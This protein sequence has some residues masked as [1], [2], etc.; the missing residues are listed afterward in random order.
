MFAPKNETVGSNVKW[1]GVNKYTRYVEGITDYQIKYEG[2]IRRVMFDT[3]HGM[4]YVVIDKKRVYLDEV[5]RVRTRTVGLGKLDPGYE[6]ADRTAA[7]EHRARF[8]EDVAS[9]AAVTNAT[10]PIPETVRVRVIPNT[11]S[12]K[13]AVMR[14]QVRGPHGE[15]VTRNRVRP[16]DADMYAIIDEVY[17][18]VNATHDTS[19]AITPTGAVFTFTPKATA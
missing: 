17:S 2:R 9:F 7:A 8:A 16:G 18:Y 5:T 6:E 19:F 3:D 11:K 10:P 15:L 4:Q 14:V 13:S 12:P 1:V